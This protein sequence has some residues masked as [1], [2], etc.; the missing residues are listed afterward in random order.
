MPNGLLRTL[1]MLLLCQGVSAAETVYVDDQLRLGVRAHPSTEEGSIAVVITGDA[2]SVLEEEENFI[3][4]RT[5]AGV[6]GWVS[7]GYVSAEPPAKSRLKDLQGEHKTL[8]QQYAGLQ[9]ELNEQ[10]EQ[11]QQYKK[12]QQKYAELQQQLKSAQQQPAKD[13]EPSVAAEQTDTLLQLQQE[14]EALKA[15]LETAPA[16]DSSSAGR[17]DLYLWG[18]IAALL[19]VSFIAGVAG[20]VQWKARR[21]AERIGGL[22]I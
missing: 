14:N 7:K 10:Q 9:K 15:R 1:L 12:L 17:P 4:I 22:Q 3:K 5:E 20:G 6:E 21:V 11:Q 16:Q 18:I 2:L 8:Q 13:E 19:L